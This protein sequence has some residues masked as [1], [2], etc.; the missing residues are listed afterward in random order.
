MGG[1]IQKEDTALPGDMHASIMQPSINT[2][3]L[4]NSAFDKLLAEFKTI[5]Q[6]WPD[7][8][9]T[10]QLLDAIEHGSIS[11]T[12]FDAW[13]RVCK[14]PSVI[15]RALS[16]KVSVRIR[17]LGIGQLKK[18]LASKQWEDLWDGL[19][20][21][22]GLLMIFSE[23]S[24]LEVK[25]ACKAIGRCAKEHDTVA[26]R[27][28]VTE[29]FKGLYPTVFQDATA[30]SNDMR[31]LS[32][33]YQ[34]LLPSCTQDLVERVLSEQ[35]AG[36]WQ[37]VRDKKLLETH[38]GSIEKTALSA[39]FEQLTPDAKSKQ[40]LSNLTMRYPS[41]VTAELGLSAS[42][43]FT[44]RLLR[45][46]IQEESMEIENEWYI[47]NAIRPLLRR[48]IRKHTSWTRTQE[49]VT[50]TLE[51]LK[52]RPQAVKF[53]TSGKGDILH[54]VALCWSRRSALFEI[55]LRRLLHL[56][57]ACKACFGDVENL[58]VGVPKSRRYALLHLCCMEVMGVDLDLEQDLSTSHGALPPSLLNSLDAA[59]ALTLLQRLRRARGDAN[60]VQLGLHGSVL[61][62]PRTLD[63]YEGDPDIYCAVLLHRNGQ[64]KE[65]ESH[66]AAI[67]EERKTKVRLT[68]DRDARAQRA[69]SVWACV[70]ASGSLKLL[71]EN[72]QWAR[73][74]IRDQL[75]ASKLFSTYYD[76]TYRLLSGPPI[77]KDYYFKP[78]DIRQRV[79]QANAIM[80]E[81]LYIA[82]SATREPHF[83]ATDWRQTLELF[84]RVLERRVELSA[85]L[86]REISLSDA[87]TYSLLWEHTIAMLVQAERLIVD[88]EYRKLRPGTLI[89]IISWS[90]VFASTPLEHCGKDV[91]RFVDNLARARDKLW[92]EL[93]AARYPDVLTLPESF[94]RG[95]PLQSLLCI[96]DSHGNGS[97]QHRCAWEYSCDWHLDHVDY[98]GTWFPSIADLA[99]V[100]PYIF[101]RV[102]KALFLDPEIA[103]RP[104]PLDE[105]VQQAIGTF[106]DSYTYAL[107]LYIAEACDSSRTEERLRAVWGHA[108]GAL[109]AQRMDKDEA[110]R[111]W[112]RT[113]PPYLLQTLSK[114]AP[115]H[116]SLRLPK[117]DSPSQTQEWNPLG[118]Q[119]I[120][121]S[122]KARSLGEATYVD[123]TALGV[124]ADQRSSEVWSQYSPPKPSVPESARRSSIWAPNLYA[125]GSESH[126]AAVL[127]ALLYLDTKY[128]TAQRLLATPFPSSGDVRYPCVY[129][130]EDFLSLNALDV[131]AAACY[132][133]QSCAPPQLVHKVAAAL[134][135][136]LISAPSSH[137]SHILEN[138]AFEVVRA[139]SQGD[140]PIIAFD[141]IL[142]VLINLPDASSWH[143]TLFNNGFLQR[144]SASDARR[145]ISKY[146][147]LVG[148]RLETQRRLKKSEANPYQ[149]EEGIPTRIPPTHDNGGDGA[150]PPSLKIT[151]LKALAQL[152]R[153]SI[154]ISDDASL[155]ILASLS[156]RVS[157]IDVRVSILRTLLSKLDGTRPELWNDVL[158]SLESFIPLIGSLNEREPLTPAALNQSNPED[159]G[160]NSTLLP[161]LQLTAIS[162]WEA[163]SPMLGAVLSHFHEL[164]DGHLSSMYV[165]R[166][167]IPIAT[168][169]EEQVA[170]WTRL[171][172]KK[173]AP[174]SMDVLATVLPPIA[175]NVSIVDVILS[176]ARVKSYR[177]P[178]VLLDKLVAY[179]KFKAEPPEPIRVFNETLDTDP[180]V[181]SRQEVEMWFQLYG[182]LENRATPSWRSLLPFERISHFEEGLSATM[183]PFVTAR[184]YQEA[185]SA[186]FRTLLS[187]DSP[188][189][190][191][192]G[193]F[194]STIYESEARKRSCW[195]D[196]GRA[197]I[198]SMIADVQRIRTREWERNKDRKPA[199]LPD[200]FFWRLL[201]LSCPP[202]DQPD[203]NP[204]ETCERRCQNFA[205]QLA[206]VLDEISGSMYHEKLLA[207][208]NYVRSNQSALL[209]A[210]YLGDVSKTRLSWLTI[211]E[212][213]RVDLAAYMMLDSRRFDIAPLQ[214]R[215]KVLLNDW[216]VNENEEVRR[217]GYKV[218]ATFFDAKGERIRDQWV[219]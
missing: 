103:L 164:Q 74:F 126:E 86:K 33:F 53:L 143:R 218:L 57:F 46:V 181:R 38:P 145:C 132:A 87:E 104:V 106:V 127:A 34:A 37:D 90:S 27:N 133:S 9:I 166:I 159:L 43:S 113:I 117:S 35:Q 171:F 153:G 91:W 188:S 30:S 64:W 114:I 161:S 169:L 125:A 55:S 178:Q 108:T 5:Q 196:Y 211:P 123:L 14:T 75:T 36:S 170:Q 77:Q 204:N 98:A 199:V 62:T 47:T 187:T 99:E 109:S 68:P 97:Y 168:C 7:N 8:E 11:P 197:M 186:I 105:P 157:Q 122:N 29:L 203:L 182:R 26:K 215:L 93:R 189:Y 152:L 185:F 131:S 118:G 120:F 71:S 85:A 146:A 175:K 101:L 17:F 65:S 78:Q 129:L 180:A 154:Y 24:V 119:S 58:L 31:P 28:R 210:L 10:E 217:T 12:A 195:E 137:V 4:R 163:D 134:I 83:Q 66:I 25:A 124:E 135:G 52:Q 156:R 165:K 202:D 89:G 92:T 183:S 13:F 144:I 177:V 80:I 216:I 60:L 73:S 107:Q 128:G 16:Q 76:E 2:S 192:L 198:E 147:L 139:L 49:I 150:K 160:R 39:V 40:R 48:A 194:V 110:V 179:I 63:E 172:L 19:G 167:M 208:K 130:D 121:T 56:V 44:I 45:D 61:A 15:K 184:T 201:L 219:R 69:L 112:K 190:N 59:T 79:E 22:A 84:T 155:E 95:L 96:W 148:E 140:R 50:I 94:P 193:S 162:S 116:E 151:T 67:I 1:S 214:G 3:L 142:E 191:R 102:K 200:I 82:C 72:I 173:Y 213:L 115:E 209:T 212:L 158:L 100:L 111:Y 174:E 32:K 23:L 20:G 70:N 207:I 42:M 54:L 81:L 41:H 51:F 21:T 176:K 6:Q 205:Q 206:N 149:L 136:R 141:L 138:A 88:E 18:G